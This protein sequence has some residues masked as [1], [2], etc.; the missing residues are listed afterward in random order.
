MFHKKFI[1]SFFLSLLFLVIATTFFISTEASATTITVGGPGSGADY[2]CNLSSAQNGIQQAFNKA[3]ELGG[4]TVILKGSTTYT[5]TQTVDIYS[6]TTLTAESGAVLK[7]GNHVSWKSMVPMIR[8]Q[9]ANN[10]KVHGFEIDGN[11]AGNTHLPRG[12]G[13]FNM[14]GF[15]GSTNVEVYDMYMHDSHG[16]AYRQYYGGNVKFHDNVIEYL[17]H[18]ALYCLQMSNIEYYNNTVVS[19]TNSGGRTFKK[20]SKYHKHCPA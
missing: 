9:T 20:Q 7:L 15:N 8:A 18:D 13:Y 11:Y 17:G 12:D 16:D 19:H 6:N 1:L 3:K 14:L 5:I 4:A 10:I 2:I